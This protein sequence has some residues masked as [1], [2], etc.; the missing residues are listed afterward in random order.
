MVQHKEQRIGV[1]VDVQNMYYSAKSLYGKK[2]NFA[3]ILKTAVEGR[4]LIRA[5][6]YVIRTDEKDKEHFYDGSRSHR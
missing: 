2:I 4:K 5:I 1:F 3:N 6:A